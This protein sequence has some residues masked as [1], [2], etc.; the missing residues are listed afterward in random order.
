MT[1]IDDY[2]FTTC[3]GVSS[4]FHILHLYLKSQGHVV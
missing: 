1:A 4:E 3:N 2:E